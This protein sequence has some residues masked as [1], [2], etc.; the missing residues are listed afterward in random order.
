M[1]GAD[2]DSLTAIFGDP[3]VM[4]AFDTAPFN[5]EQMN[6]W[7]ARNLAH[8]NE[9]GFGLF[10]VILKS[11]SLLIGDCG[12]EIM[13]ID[14]VASTELG[15]DFRSDYWNRGFAT[16]AASAVRDFAFG[17][18]HIPRLISLIRVDNAASRRVSEKI[19]M[20]FDREVVRGGIAY[21]IYSLE[22]P[23]HFATDEAAPT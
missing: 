8:Q 4:A 23:S 9:H 5:R 6:Q 7:L 22:S 11:E 16:E 15:Y 20:R 10:S 18:L 21:W 13:Q 17:T 1:T 19:G 3:R 14:G 12:L 2:F